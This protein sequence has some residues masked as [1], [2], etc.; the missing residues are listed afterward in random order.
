MQTVTQYQDAVKTT[1]AAVSGALTA[2]DKWQTAGVTVRSHFGTE[3]VLLEIKAQFIADAIIPAMKKKH[4]EALAIELPRKNSKEYN[5]LDAS[6]VAKWNDLNDAKKKARATAHTMFNRIV[7]YAFPKEPTA[8]E[9]TTLKTRL[10]KT[11]SE[12]IGKIEKAENPDFDAVQ[13][14]VHLRAAVAVIAK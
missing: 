14:L 9:T 7:G 8:G 1:I 12:A 11:L 3:T 5:A 6:G 2:E 10:V 13:A 4:A